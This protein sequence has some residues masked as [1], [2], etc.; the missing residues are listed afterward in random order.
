MQI[1]NQTVQRGYDL[2]TGQP[3]WKVVD[4]YP[5]NFRLEYSTSFYPRL[6]PGFNVLDL[7]EPLKDTASISF[8]TLKE[9]MNV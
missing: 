9:K 7:G 8:I 3:L 2:T 5:N 6:G 4:S 1:G